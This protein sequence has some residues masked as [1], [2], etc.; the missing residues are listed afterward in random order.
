MDEVKSKT[1]LFKSLDEFL[2]IRVHV[3]V[4]VLSIKTECVERC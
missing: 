1:N 4:S 3:I 2:V